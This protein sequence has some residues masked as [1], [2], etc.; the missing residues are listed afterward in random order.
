MQQDVV[1]FENNWKHSNRTTFTKIRTRIYNGIRRYPNSMTKPSR[2]NST[3]NNDP[4]MM[5][6]TKRHQRVVCRFINYIHFSCISLRQTKAKD[7][8]RTVETAFSQ[9][10]SNSHGRGTRTYLYLILTILY[11]RFQ[12]QC[13]SK[14]GQTIVDKSSY[15]SAQ[16]IPSRIYAIRHFCAAC[17][18]L[19]NYTCI[20]CGARYCSISCRDVH[21]NTR[22]FIFFG[23]K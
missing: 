4:P 17:G 21:D 15:F 9:K 19:S 5:A 3:N 14:D 18:L 2:N 22:L 11:R 6:A 1:D 10:L 23:Q 16:A 12:L 20:R 7:S 13:S 8:Y